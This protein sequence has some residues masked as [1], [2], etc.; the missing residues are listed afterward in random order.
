MELSR[1]IGWEYLLRGGV[2]GACDAS[3]I[4]LAMLGA[5]LFDIVIFALVFCRSRVA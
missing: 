2:V 1:K 5:S 3:D 4:Q